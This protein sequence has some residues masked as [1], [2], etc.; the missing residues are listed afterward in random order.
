MTGVH[1]VDPDHGL[2]RGRSRLM[3]K[4]KD[5]A[6]KEGANAVPASGTWRHRLAE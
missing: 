4:L 6:T 5:S 2:S 1:I 3:A